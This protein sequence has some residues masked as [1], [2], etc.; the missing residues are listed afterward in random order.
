[1]KL[2]SKPSPNHSARPAGTTIDCVVLHADASVHAEG[3]VSW[4]QSPKSKVS[5]HALVDRDG[6]IYVFVPTE[7]RAWHAGVS[8]FDGRPNCNDYAIGL[9][10]ANRND[11]REEYTAKQYQ[12]GALLV[13]E[14]MRR[15][16][17]ITLDR[18]TT[19]A[20]V[21]PGRKTDPGPRFDFAA[22]KRLIA[23]EVQQWEAE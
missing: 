8:S 19:H 16:P 3:S 2:V 12:A 1:M 10:F 7:R 17:A 9:S 22:F 6:T 23:L 4:I 15:Y 14:W 21:S 13:A 20:A 18:I 5:Y 11:G